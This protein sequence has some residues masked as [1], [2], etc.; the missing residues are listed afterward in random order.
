MSQAP[1]RGQVAL[2]TGSTSGIGLGIAERLAAAGAHIVLNGLGTADEVEATRARI[3]GTHG[4]EVMFDG[5]DM[6]RPDDIEAM[7]LGTVAR[8]GRIDLLVNNA[9]IQHVAPIEGFPPAKWDAILA[10]NLSAAFH[11]IRHALPAMKRQ[12]FGRIVNVASASSRPTWPPS[13]ASRA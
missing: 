3:A 9:G 6:S 10:I 12:G 1:Y 4:V 13:T 5:A 2:V 7:L 11:T 8:F